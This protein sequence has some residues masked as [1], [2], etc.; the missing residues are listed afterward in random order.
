[1][2]QVGIVVPVYRNSE[3]LVALAARVRQAMVANGLDYRLLFVVDASPDLSWEVVQ[4][5][6]MADGNV[7]G[8]RLRRNVGQHAAIMAGIQAVDGDVIA[9]MDA[10]LQDPPE[11]LPTLA[12]LSRE[13][14]STVFAQR[15]GRYQSRSRMLTS[16]AFKTLLS[17]VSGV[18]ADVG[19][20]FVMPADVAAAVRRCSV[21]AP[22]IV[23]LAYHFSSR[24]AL[25]PFD[26]APRAV[27][28]SSYSALGRVRAA[29]RSL[30]C[31]L[32]CRRLRPTSLLPSPGSRFPV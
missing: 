21:S 12:R 15:R 9:V 16:R 23:V 18:P 24:I 27:G 13:S 31:A 3:T 17:R 28:T 1:V 29:A 4:Q 25:L 14:G 20:F 10:D 8:L 7:A 2:R 6:A 32:K 26:R 19:T 22:Q 11:L 5:I 30:R